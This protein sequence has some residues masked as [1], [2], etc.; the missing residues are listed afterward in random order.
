MLP[1]V[2]GRGKGTRE[3]GGRDG[4]CEDGRV[5]EATG[6]LRRSAPLRGRRTAG[7]VLLG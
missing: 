2:V 4:Q 6:V 5:T 1:A 3:A 7:R